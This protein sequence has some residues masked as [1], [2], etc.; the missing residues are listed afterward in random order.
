MISTPFPRAPRKDLWLSEKMP[1]LEKEKNAKWQFPASFEATGSLSCR[2]NRSSTASSNSPRVFVCQFPCGLIFF[3]FFLYAHSHS[4][5]LLLFLLITRLISFLSFNQILRDVTIGAFNCL[6]LSL[7][8]SSQQTFSLL[9]VKLF[10]V[11]SVRTWCYINVN[12][13]NCI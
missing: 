6:S 1:K 11:T 9:P 2:G 4:H 10:S 5:V 3:L 13:F 12:H 8:S 7:T